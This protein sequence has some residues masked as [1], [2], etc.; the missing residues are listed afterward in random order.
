MGLP[1][2]LST[3]MHILFSHLKHKPVKIKSQPSSVLGCVSGRPTDCHSSPAVNGAAGGG[4]DGHLS[5]PG[6]GPLTARGGARHHQ[7]K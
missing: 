6:A 7:G 5:L 3:P 1:V 2:L 4:A